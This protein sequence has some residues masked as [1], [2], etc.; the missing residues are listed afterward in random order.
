MKLKRVKILDFIISDC[1]LYTKFSRMIIFGSVSFLYLLKLSVGNEFWYY[2][3]LLAVGFNRCFKKATY[4]ISE[5]VVWRC[6]VKKLFLEI[7]QNSQ[8][9]TCAR[10]SFLIKLQALETL[11]QVFSCEFCEISKNTL[12]HRTPLVA[13]SEILDILKNH[14]LLSS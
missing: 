7:L 12:Y 3:M 14:A 13:A 4:Q 6:S 1:I 2:I 9:N 5:V 8:K 10:N 11:A